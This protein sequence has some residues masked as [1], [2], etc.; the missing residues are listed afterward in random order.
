[1]LTTTRLTRCRLGEREQRLHKAMVVQLGLAT[2]CFVASRNRWLLISGT[3]KEQPSSPR[4]AELLSTT[5]APAAA[6]SGACFKLNSDPAEKS[7]RSK[8]SLRFR[9]SSASTA[10]S[11][12]PNETNSPAERSDTKA[13]TDAA[14]KRRSS[15]IVRRLSSDRSVAPTT[16]T[17]SP[18]E[19]L[20]RSRSGPRSRE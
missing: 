18:L 1:M 14:G 8:D 20:A 10:M 4:K 7:A 11:S 17:R 3:T 6:N 19:S 2:I 9:A 5:Q 12:P 15:R 13:R 16:A